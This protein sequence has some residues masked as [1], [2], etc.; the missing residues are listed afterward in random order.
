MNIWKEIACYGV[1]GICEDN[2]SGGLMLYTH[3]INSD[4][5]SIQLFI[6]GLEEYYCAY[7][8]G[9]EPKKGFGSSFAKYIEEEKQY[10]KGPQFKKDRHYW[11]N[12]YRHQRDF[13]FPAGRTPFTNTLKSK[14]F[15]IEGEEYDLLMEFCK[16]NKSSF[17]AAIMTLLAL[18]TYCVTGKENFCL[19]NLFHGRLLPKYKKTVGDMFNTYPL[20]YDV[21]GD[22]R[23]STYISEN[24]G[25]YV[26]AMT[27]GRFPAS[28][29]IMMCARETYIK[30]FGYNYIWLLMSYYEVPIKNGEKLLELMTPTEKFIVGIF[31]CAVFNDSNEHRVEFIENYQSKCISDE[32]AQ[33]IME[34][35]KR[36]LKLSVENDEMTINELRS[37]LSSIASGIHRR[38]RKEK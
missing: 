7:I 8:N 22:E 24:Y 11:R 1:I 33:R 16:K 27:H 25:S 3:H 31:Y 9:E 38:K 19:Y 6:D 29:Q 13:S 34:V 36:I 2:N 15:V 18:T 35:F 21:P 30:R 17:P 20:F 32:C 4:G 37:Q 28:S 14:S 5:Y 12:K 23:I 26:E 10:L